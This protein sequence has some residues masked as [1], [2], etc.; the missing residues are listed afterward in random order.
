MII[1]HLHSEHVHKLDTGSFKD[2]HLVNLTVILDLQFW[3][4]QRKQILVQHFAINQHFGGSVC[5]GVAPNRR[6]DD[7]IKH[8]Y[9]LLPIFCLI[10]L[11]LT[12]ERLDKR[13]YQLVYL[14]LETFGKS[15][16]KFHTMSAASF[17]IRLL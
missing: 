15:L 14:L 12:T 13:R 9:L 10:L 1:L 6:S 8:R 17:R 5:I 7:Q 16:H 4:H 3:N 2:G 11:I